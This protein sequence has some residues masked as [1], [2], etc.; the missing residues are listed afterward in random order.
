MYDPEQCWDTDFVT[1]FRNPVPTYG[2]PNHDMF[3]MN[4]VRGRELGL[5]W[6]TEVWEWC[7][8]EKLY[9]WSQLKNYWSDNCLA[10]LPNLVY[11][12]KNVEA[13]VGMICEKPLPGAIVGPTAACVLQ[14]QYYNLREGDRFFFDRNGFTYDQLNVLKKFNLGKILCITTNLDYVTENVFKTPNAYSNKYQSCNAYDDITE[15]DLSVLWSTIPYANGDY[16]TCKEYGG[17]G[18]QPQYQNASYGG[19]QNK[20]YAQPYQAPAAYP[21]PAYAAPAY[22][23]PAY[24]APAYPAPAYPA[25][26]YPA[27][28]YPAPAYPAP[29]YN[30]PAYP[31]SY[32]G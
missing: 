19:Y 28:A 15:D 1:E 12:V 23:A 21:A 6:Y 16:R 29:A 13:Y 31:A 26:A 9:D 17:Y 3:W 20:T 24:P 4:L 18:Y 2:G 11:H 27:P 25:P 32:S 5:P 22:P 8:M 7:G 30:K 14:R 10:N